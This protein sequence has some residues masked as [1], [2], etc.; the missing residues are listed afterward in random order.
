MIAQLVPALDHEEIAD[1][2]GFG[3]CINVAEDGI[4]ILDQEHRASQ[5]VSFC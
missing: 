2:A 1:L 5:T 4:V 3:E